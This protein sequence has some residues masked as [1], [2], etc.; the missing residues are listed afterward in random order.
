MRWSLI[1]LLGATALGMGCHRTDLSRGVPG[2]AAPMAAPPDARGDR[3]VPVDVVVLPDVARDLAPPVPDVS[4][5]PDVRPSAP[6]PPPPM[7]PPPIV[8]GCTPREEVCNNTDDDCDGQVDE[9]IAPIP[10]PDGGSRLCVAGKLSECPRR[11]EVCVPGGQR[12]CFVPFCTFWGRQICA[13]DGR[14][15]G[16]CI[17]S[18]SAPSEC[19]VIAKSKQRSAELEKCCLDS[20]Y[21]CLDDFDLDGDG[22]RT[23][24]LGKCAGVQC[25]P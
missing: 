9:G 4:S 12:I 10:C 19:A 24:M 5:P 13:P 1:F 23:E 14:G 18:K 22:N 15:F 2:D 21:C 6:P 17:E 7:P 11:C 16:A 20:G 8:P 25:G 3:A